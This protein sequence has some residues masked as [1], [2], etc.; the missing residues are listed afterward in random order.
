MIAGGNVFS[1]II[2]WLPLLPDCV[3]GWLKVHFSHDLIGHVSGQVHELFLRQPGSIH[4]IG[5][6][7]EILNAPAQFFGETFHKSADDDVAHLPQR[8]VTGIILPAAGDA[9]VLSIL[10][11]NS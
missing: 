9:L 3:D 1:I 6:A 10:P 8:K 7:E 11:W 5:L 4:R 2:L